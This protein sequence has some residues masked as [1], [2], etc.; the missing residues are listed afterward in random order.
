MWVL[1]DSGI[2]N[3][4]RN[5]VLFFFRRKFLYAE[6]GGNVAEAA[7]GAPGDNHCSFM[8]GESEA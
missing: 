8:L 5:A 3:R 7:V 1:T 2:E 4:V 6:V